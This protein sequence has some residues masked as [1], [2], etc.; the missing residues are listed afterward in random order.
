MFIHYDD[1]GI[2]TTFSKITIR[3]RKLIRYISQS[4]RIY[5]EFYRNIY[6]WQLKYLLHVFE[7]KLLRFEIKRYK[8]RILWHICPPLCRIDER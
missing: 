2:N 3:Q 5:S 6:F 4:V 1:K 7:L 8:S